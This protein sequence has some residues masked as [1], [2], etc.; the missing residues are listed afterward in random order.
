[1]QS[2]TNMNEAYRRLNPFP[3][4]NHDAPSHIHTR[5]SNTRPRVILGQD[6]PLHALI[7][8]IVL[9]CH[10]TLEMAWM[11]RVSALVLMRFEPGSLKPDT[12]VGR[13]LDGISQ[14]ELV[15]NVDV[16]R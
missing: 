14:T 5:A 10:A 3:I 2:N 15:W 8:R 1:M 7:G 16:V 6:L 9:S 13:I 12:E 11:I 4:N